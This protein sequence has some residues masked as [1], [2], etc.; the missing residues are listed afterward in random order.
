MTRRH[1]PAA[2]LL[3]ASLLSPVAAQAELKLIERFTAPN[4]ED[5]DFFG[6][7]IDLFGRV[8]AVR[9]RNAYRDTRNSQIHVFEL[10]GSQPGDAWNGVA[11]DTFTH[12][13][14]ISRGQDLAIQS[15]FDRN[16]VVLVGLNQNSVNG[17]PA[18]GVVTTY[19][20]ADN[21]LGPV[22]TR[23]GD[24]V[25]SDLS[26]GAA[27]GRSI[28]VDEPNRF[29]SRLIVGAASNNTTGSPLPFGAEGDGAAFV[30]ER[31]FSGEW[32]ELA[33][34]TA[35]DLVGSQGIG[36]RF[37]TS[38]DI[39]GDTAIVGAFADDYDGPFQPG[40][41][42]AYVFRE[43]ENGE[44]NE[45]QKLTEPFGTDFGT[46]V[47]IHGDT[48][49]VLADGTNQLYVYQEDDQDTWNLTNTING[50]AGA[51]VWGSRS[52]AI[53]EE[54]LAV[55]FHDGQRGWVDVY[56]KSE[57]NEWQ[58]AE[59]LTSPSSGATDYFGFNIAI[60]GDRVA[61][62]D[63]GSRP[64]FVADFEEPIQGAPGE[65]FLF[66]QGSGV[67]GD[68]NADGVVNEADDALWRATYGSTTSLAA[69]HNG[70]GV[71]DAGDYTFW[72]DQAGG[73]ASATGVP[74]PGA[75]LLTLGALTLGFNHRRRVTL[76]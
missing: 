40:L 68:T 43:G 51:R 24:L 46:S 56:T 10:A 38:V 70:N 33:K 20:A 11:N 34:L 27:F 63:P 69:D 19:T 57:A 36:P 29:E 62:A 54:R 65:V 67:I 12:P 72:R 71:V 2:C 6:G 26:P 50:G 47:A 17:V 4:S 31:A 75:M 42:S 74:E 15:E 13:L 45:Q 48:A 44:W 21:R 64:D 73:N 8:L 23:Q 39:S 22:W 18:N 49:L 55:G 61:V 5:G 58:F 76:R 16:P 14:Q 25:S 66:Q 37:G 53:N 1:L 35:D 52:L 59:E 3:L 60:D 30:Y 7:S 32:I 28:A 9:S 41:G